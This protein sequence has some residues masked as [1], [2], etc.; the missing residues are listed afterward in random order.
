LKTRLV[1]FMALHGE[2]FKAKL[3]TVNEDSPTAGGDETRLGPPG[4][5]PKTGRLY[6]GDAFGP[7]YQIMR[8]L[9]AGGMGVVYQAWDEVLGVAVAMK[10]I[11]RDSGLG[12]EEMQDVERR[13][14]RE[15]LLARQVT[16]RNVVRIHDLGD[17]EGTKYITMTYVDGEDL[18]TTLKRE[19][20]LPVQRVM[21]IAWQ[22]ASALRA[23]HEA[24]VV[25]RDLKPANIMI[26]AEDHALVMDFG[27]AQSATAKPTVTPA[28][29]LAPF[30]PK[31]PIP[32]SLA[33]HSSETMMAS[34][35][36]VSPA[37]GDETVMASGSNPSGALLFPPSGSGSRI[38]AADSITVGSVVGT[39]EYM[40]PEQS[41]GDA[42]DH[43][44]D[45]YA[46][47][48]ILSDLLLG[49][50]K[51]VDGESAWDAMQKRV[52]TPPK[53]LAER[54]PSIPAAFDAVITKCLQI[55]PDDRYAT[56]A[57]LV[58]AIGKLDNDGN[59]IPEPVTKR[60]TPAM[61]AAGGVALAAIVGGTY[62]FARGNGPVD[63]KPVS[64]LV[65]D[66]ANA[67][68]DPVFSGLAEQ[69]FTVN[70][71]GASFITAFPHRDAMRVVNEI[72]P[73]AKLDDP[74]ARLVAMREGLNVIVGGSITSQGSGYT[75]GVKATNVG[76][77]KVL[78]D[79]STTAA[80]K[81]DVL[82]AVGRAAERVR[83]TLGDTA[84]SSASTEQET[85]TASN[86]EA[87][88]AYAE[89]QDLNWA[90][91]YADAIAGYQKTLAI[92]A[93]FGRAHAGLAAAYANSGRPDEALA[94]YEKALTLLDRMTEREKL[95]TRAGYYLLKRNYDKA[96]EESEALLK[97]YP[98]DTSGMANLA[99][100]QFYKRDMKTAQQMG[101]R[102]SDLYPN[103]VIRKNNTALFA[104]Y[105]GDFD[106]AIILAAKVLELN[107]AFVKAYVAQGLSQLAQG[108]TAEAAAT[109]NKLNQIDTPVAHGFAATGLID[110]ALFEHRDADALKLVAD[111]IAVDRAAQ[112]KSSLG[113]RLA[114]RAGVLAAKGDKAGALRDAREAATLGNDESI[115]YPAGRAMIDAG[116]SSSALE[117]AADLDNRLEN[118]PRLYGALL[119]GEAA[120]AAG[121][122][123][124]ALNA[125]QDAQKLGDSWMGRLSLGRAYLALKALPEASTEFDRCLSRRGEATALFLDDRPTY[126]LFNELGPLVQKAK[127]P[128]GI[129]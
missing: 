14:K 51:R 10:M 62:Y 87:A 48:L 23:V 102:A 109:Y 107:P 106:Y 18:A 43:R 92:D 29:D 60:I 96:I 50:R 33:T 95:R 100:A 28:V 41:R 19:G 79:W 12:T 91:K 68:N 112:D 85:F 36:Q 76:D 63:H 121:R 39:L 110:L 40:S 44:T 49:K 122:A 111:A 113:R 15:L 17:V 59:L 67:S 88:K 47:G 123:R 56:T 55:D 98:A 45:I 80:N 127:A 37:H 70:V 108:H 83:K 16:H 20:K 69:A 66:F 42:V 84:T 57:D 22:V 34:P 81:D 38:S 61:M 78:L 120:L 77:Q 65:A 21:R 128:T 35:A 64:V 126:H 129:R 71:E 30:Q 89:A 99:L 25:H 3:A 74:T 7:R 94:S 119:R 114:L 73:G 5:A 103:N 1:F 75:I 46:F 24:N 101:R 124:A 58:D 11:R 118:E 82:P 97:K 52:K 26:D 117:I 31:R 27:V 54:D 86:L 93:N 104:M 90:G 72:K 116:D 105:A 2:S 125:F 53:H 4:P 13:F 32:P 6:P 115:L 8:E 9:G